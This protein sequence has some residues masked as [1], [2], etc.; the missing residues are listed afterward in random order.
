[1]LKKKGFRFL[2]YRRNF[3]GLSDLNDKKLVECKFLMYID[4]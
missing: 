1:M 2:K 4:F 3:Q